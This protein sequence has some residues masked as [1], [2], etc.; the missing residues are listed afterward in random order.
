MINMIKMAN[1]VAVAGLLAGGLAAC[2]GDNGSGGGFDI[3]KDPIIEVQFNQ[4]ILF[5]G[6]KVNVAVTGAVGEE[7]TVGA[8]DLLNT[9]QADSVLGITEMSVTSNPP[10]AF[11]LEAVDGSPLPTAGA[12]QLDALNT[13]GVDPART[14]KTVK[15]LF[16]RPAPGTTVSGAV[17]I[18][19]NSVKDKDLTFPLQVD[20][21]QPKIQLLPAVMDFGNVGQG[22]D[23]IL[24][25]N[26]TN[27]GNA[28]LEVSSFT[29]QGD[30]GY[31]LIDGTGQW[32]AS[33]E[34][35]NGVQFPEPITVEAG[36][37]HLM[38][39]RFTPE[40]P[41]KA[42]GLVRF[43]SNDPE[44]GVDGAPVVLQANAG[45]PCIAISPKKVDFGGKLIGKVSTMEVTVTSCGDSPVEI[46]GLRLLPDAEV[47][48]VGLSTDFGLDLSGLDPSIAPGT[49]Q[50]TADDPPVS[51][52]V[53]ADGVRTFTVTYVPD[54][55][56]P[57]DA[58][59]K[60]IPDLG[61]IEILTN[62]FVPEL[63]VEVRGF[64][65][66]T[67]C[68]TAIIKVQE[69][70]EVIP[71]TKLHLIGSQ[72]FASSGDIT[73]YEWTVQQPPGSQSVFMPSASA[74]DPTFET[75][76][77]GTYIFNLEVWDEAD[78]KSCVPAEFQ[79]IVNPDEAIHIELLWNTPNDP[80]QT[81]EGPEAGAD[82]D[83][84]F[85]HPFASTP[86]DIDG[87]GQPDPYFDGQFDCFWFN[88]NPDWA[89]HDPMV[90]DD[91]GLD[92]DDTDGA[93][94]ENV[95]LNI[96]EHGLTYR[97]AVHYWDDHG[98]GDSFATVRI[99]IHS[100]LVFQV[101]EVLLSHH[102]LWEVATVAWPSG[103]VTPVTDAGGGNLII[104]N[105]EHPLF[106]G[107]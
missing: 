54:V 97:V 64:G 7:T 43:F 41:E 89:S 85:L 23:K 70:E 18:V 86:Y 22:E 39:V 24:N 16:T 68:P 100:V 37:S 4:G 42:E 96:P 48:D 30:T 53:G 66:E 94:P 36:K 49:T 105:Y 51:I 81:D 102:D 104:P 44:S 71:Q 19:S 88:P 6:D 47:P 92:R 28:P 62:T 83:L 91:P 61:F 21:A 35:V 14:T 82:V 77:A 8:F 56:N 101:E 17:H 50:L 65:V 45:G 40:G 34:T 98:F 60:P 55:I 38:K 2:G 10:G 80:D 84:H 58:N 90:D 103:L 31:T 69:G 32:T 15:L 95:N 12:W 78:E 46:Q 75:N 26:I 29:L 9:G 73:K 87:D 106:L 63:R 74:P 5:N 1:A 52:P 99:Y 59:Q 107:N 25:L 93:G 76:V 72:S 27:T 57:L 13:E 11:R 79:V 33:N 20:E 67:E 3:N